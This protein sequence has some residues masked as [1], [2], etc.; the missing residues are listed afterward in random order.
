MALLPPPER[1]RLWQRWNG[2]LA[3]RLRLRC[4]YPPCGREFFRPAE[5]RRGAH[6]FCSKACTD[7]FKRGRHLTT[8]GAQP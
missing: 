5:R 2:N 1:S 4:D 6:D 8:P 7:A 3:N